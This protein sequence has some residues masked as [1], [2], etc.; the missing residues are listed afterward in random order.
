MSSGKYRHD[1]NCCSVQD[2]R[3]LCDH[4]KTK[5]PTPEQV[6]DLIDGVS[7]TIKTLF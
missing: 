4:D 6:D 5:E 1:A 3:N 7:K 2:I